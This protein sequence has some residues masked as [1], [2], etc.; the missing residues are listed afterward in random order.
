MTAWP[1][2][3][4]QIEARLCLLED[5]IGRGEFRFEPVPLP[6]ELGPLPPACRARAERVMAAVQDIGH[7]VESAMADLAANLTRPASM[8][9]PRPTPAYIDRRA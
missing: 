1:A 8:P 6:A 4:D 2:V 3:L 9:P 5:A 7:R